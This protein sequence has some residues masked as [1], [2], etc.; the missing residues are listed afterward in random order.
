ML[1][2]IFCITDCNYGQE[3]KKGSS[4][5]LELEARELNRQVH[6]NKYQMPKIEELMDTVGQ[7]ITVLFSYHLADGVH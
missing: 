7:T 6:K 3:V 4:A 5:K 2:Q 1:G